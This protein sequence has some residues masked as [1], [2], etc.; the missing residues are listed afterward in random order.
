M[1]FNTDL[2]MVGV[3]LHDGSWAKHP[4]Q[5]SRS[6]GEVFMPQK[7]VIAKTQNYAN[8]CRRTKS[9][10]IIQDKPRG[11]RKSAELVVL[12]LPSSMTST[13]V[14]RRESRV[15]RTP[16]RDSE[17]NGVCL[18]IGLYPP[19]DSVHTVT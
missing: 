17:A 12:D 10:S 16:P 9:P 4:R 7:R 19:K 6:L 15:Q 5:A 13:Q 2:Q 14:R 8:G 1:R 3:V 11:S 18:K